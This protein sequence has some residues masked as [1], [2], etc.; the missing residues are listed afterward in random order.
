MGRRNHPSLVIPS[1]LSRAKSR[2]ARTLLFL[3]LLVI[4]NAATARQTA[5]LGAE[6]TLSQF[7]TLLRSQPQR[8]G[9]SPETNRPRADEIFFQL[10]ATQGREAAARQSLDRLAGWTQAAQA[11]LA[12]Q[13]APALDV[14]VLRF[15][16]ATAQAR[17]AQFEAVRRRALR[18]AN[19]SLGR[20]PDSPLVALTTPTEPELAGKPNEAGTIQPDARRANSPPVKATESAK[21]LA[22]FE[23]DLLPQAQ[24]LLG[25]VY[26]NYL[27]GGISL[28]ALLWQEEQVYQT[29]L[30]YR[31]LMV[32]VE[33][34]L[35]AAE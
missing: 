21:R 19:Q 31:L 4:P 24:E 32:E 15:S 10:L 16:E 35:A 17:L 7:R 18:Q 9:Q 28:S 34:E 23:K 27:F 30:Q 5:G 14:E 2:E 33:R 12:A 25:K 13:S 11:R 6:M 26:Q 22:Q 1:D 29:E 8:A 20:E 3:L